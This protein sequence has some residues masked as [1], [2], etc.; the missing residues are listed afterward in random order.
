MGNIDIGFKDIIEDVFETCINLVTDNQGNIIFLSK[1]YAA[2]LNVD[3]AK[4]IGKPVIDVIPGT[5]MHIVAKTGKAEFGSIFQL[6]TGESVVC[7]RLPVF[8]D[9]KVIAV[10]T[11]GSFNQPAEGVSTIEALQKTRHLIQELLHYKK[12]LGQLRGAQYSIDQI[13]GMASNIQAIKAMVQKVAQTQST[14]LISGETGT[15]KELF[16]QAIHQLSPRSHQPLVRI[17]CAA[18]PTELFETELFG[19]EEGAFTGARKGGKM[20]KFELANHGTMIF[21]EIQQMPLL[22]QSK[23]LRV[24]QEREIER[25]GSNK[26]MKIDVRLIFVTNK[27]LFKLVTKGEFRE[28]FYYRINT[29]PLKI[30]PL[31]ERIEDVPLLAEHI[32]AKINHR[33]SLKITG[34]DKEALQLF[35]HHDWPGNVRELEHTLERAAN[36]AISGPLKMEYFDT[37]ALRIQKRSAV[38]LLKEDGHLSLE[39]KLGIIKD[40]AEKE[41]IKNAL[42]TCKGNKTKAA[43]LLKVARPLLYQ[44]IKRLNLDKGK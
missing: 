11:F 15:G 3:P 12:D 5:R 35:Q 8:R 14:V 28:D 29:V 24:I 2:K 7:N 4:V 42:E 20:G 10:A 40:L 19:Y 41:I 21:D 33:L 44:K 39:Q 43:E 31:R 6:N 27:N 9:G 16:A 32:L 23:L 25:V 30:P 17:N 36:I 22:L 18:I 37:L 38:N 34:I 1:G 26:P 13:I